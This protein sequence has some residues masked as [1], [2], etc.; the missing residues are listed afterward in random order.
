MILHQIKI[1]GLHGLGPTSTL[2]FNIIYC[3][4]AIAICIY[5]QYQSTGTSKAGEKG[6]ILQ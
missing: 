2:N 1:K 6:F 5:Q 4:I 3:S